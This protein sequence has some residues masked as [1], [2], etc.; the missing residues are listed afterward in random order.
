M[1]YAVEV[2]VTGNGVTVLVGVYTT[3]LIESGR[4]IVDVTLRVLNGGPTDLVPVRITHC[5]EVV[6]EVTVT[7]SVVAT[8]TKI[9]A[10]LLS[11]MAKNL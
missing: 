6:V 7:A 10:P 4:V 2:R 11:N 8:R 3:V 1:E 5:S 9:A